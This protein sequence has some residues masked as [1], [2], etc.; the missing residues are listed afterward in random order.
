MAQGLGDQEYSNSTLPNEVDALTLQQRTM[1]KKNIILFVYYWLGFSSK[2]PCWEF[3]KLDW[4]M[5]PR[6]KA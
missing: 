3:G 1:M 2:S 4:N 5:G 6:L